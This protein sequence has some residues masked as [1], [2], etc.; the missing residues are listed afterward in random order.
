MNS[1]DVEGDRVVEVPHVRRRHRDELL[2]AAVEV[3]ADDSGEGTKVSV[4]RSEQQRSPIDDMSLGGD[5][6]S[7]ADIGDEPPDLHDISRELVADVEWRVA[8]AL[9][10]RVRVVDVDVG[11]TDAGSA[12]PD[13]YLIT[14]AL[15]LRPILQ[16]EYGSVGFLDH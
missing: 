5:A 8:Q 3:D 14:A 15:L 6:V 10:R 1:P 12:H 7:L 4:A 9:G 2:E 13:E 11:S 16:L